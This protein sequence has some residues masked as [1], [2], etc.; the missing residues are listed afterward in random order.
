MLK[1][2]IAAY[3]YIIGKIIVASYKKEIVKN[4]TPQLINSFCGNN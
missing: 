4:Y 2:Y 3:K 1:K